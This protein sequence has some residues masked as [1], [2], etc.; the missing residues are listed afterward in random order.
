M[1]NRRRRGGTRRRQNNTGS[2]TNTRLLAG[3]QSG[4]VRCRVTGSG[5]TPIKSNN[6]AGAMGCIATSTTALRSTASGI[7]VTRVRLIVP[8]PSSGNVNSARLTWFG[9]DEHESQAS[10]IASTNNPAKCAII[11]ARPP[12][13]SS[14]AFWTDGVANLMSVHAPVGTIVELAVIIRHAR[15]G[16]PGFV[17]DVVVAGLTTGDT[18]YAAVSTT[19]LTIDDG[20]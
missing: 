3:T 18:Y 4:L 16:Q 14:A 10:H 6:L 1:P 19:L 13:D 5:T 12:R 11:A 20:N 17:P 2:R 15:P 8:P 7:K 9:G